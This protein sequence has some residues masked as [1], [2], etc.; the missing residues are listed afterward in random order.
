MSFSSH[1]VLRCVSRPFLQLLAYGLLQFVKERL[2]YRHSL[3]T[4]VTPPVEEK[5]DEMHV[6]WQKLICPRS[7]ITTCFVYRR[8]TTCTSTS[9]KY[10]A[11]GGEMLLPEEPDGPF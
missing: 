4:V 1:F 2:L 10:R 9:P 3:P 7:R 8:I 6:L 5:K 11:I